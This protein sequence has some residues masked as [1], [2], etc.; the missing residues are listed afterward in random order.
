MIR[1]REC[2]VRERELHPAH[3]S[4]VFKSILVS[5]ISWFTLFYFQLPPSLE[6]RV[7][8]RRDCAK[9]K[10]N[11]EMEVKYLF[12]TNYLKKTLEFVNE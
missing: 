12:C 5:S 1:N 7:N 11:F 10:Y 3:L 9:H 2:Q 8:K 4:E 6:V